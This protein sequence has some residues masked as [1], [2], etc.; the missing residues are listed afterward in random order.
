MLDI[1]SQT[2]TP[3]AV[4]VLGAAGAVSVNDGCSALGVPIAPG[5]TL[6]GWGVE[7]VL[8]NGIARMKL[9]S[10]D[11]VD[12]VNGVDIAFAATNIVSAIFKSEN[13]VYKSGAR[14]ITAGT[15]TAQTICSGITLDWYAG[16]PT[17]QGSYHMPNNVVVGTATTAGAALVA[18]AW[19]GTP[20]A[21]V[22]ALPQ[23]KYAIL[24]AV[25]AA[26]THGAIRFAHADFGG[27]K[28]GFVMC[29]TGVAANLAGA[30]KSD[31][32]LEPG[33]QFVTLGQALDIP[34]CPVFSVT[35]MG[36]GLVI[37]LMSP[38]IATPTVVL[39]LAKVG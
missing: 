1:H 3:G 25:C 12:P 9:S 17:I 22:Q 37:E 23:G 4:L 26:V 14:V 39:W 13:L 10:Q 21:P 35:N 8:A 34:C 15:N 31:L 18:N 28:P 32:F 11:L 29:E 19:A 7:S 5:A 30:S 27:K 33:V 2:I 16:G 20:F 24:G 36:T 38:T 6:V